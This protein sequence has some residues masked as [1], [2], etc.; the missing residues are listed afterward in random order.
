[1]LKSKKVLIIGGGYISIELTEA[2]IKNGLEVVIIEKNEVKDFVLKT[3]AEI[4]AYYSKGR[5]GGKTEI[6]YTL[7]KHVKK[8]PSAKAGF[9]VY[10][11]YK[12]IF[13]FPDKHENQLK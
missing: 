3:A 8:P 11:D 4:C 10:T 5:E 6:V 2:F 7:K 9:V 13:V 1:M 12:S